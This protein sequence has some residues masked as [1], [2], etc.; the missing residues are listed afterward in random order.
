MRSLSELVRR[1]DAICER[2]NRTRSAV[3]HRS[4]EAFVEQLEQEE[5]AIREEAKQR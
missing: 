4:V 1:I 5:S 3:V 2:Q